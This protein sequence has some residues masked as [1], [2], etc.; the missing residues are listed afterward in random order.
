MLTRTDTLNRKFSWTG[1]RPAGLGIDMG[2][3]Q[4][5]VVWLEQFGEGDLRAVYSSIPTF[6]AEPD[7]SAPPS[8]ELAA[9]TALAIEPENSESADRRE[10]GNNPFVNIRERKERDANNWNAVHLKQ[11]SERISQ[12]IGGSRA[13]KTELSVT[14]SMALC[15]FRSVYVSKEARTDQ[16][17]LQTALAHSLG[18]KEQRCVAI[19][20][21]EDGSQKHRAFS[22]SESLTGNIGKSLDALG[23]PPRRVDG[24]PWCMAR[25][26]RDL[27]GQP[28][29]NEI[30]LVVDWG[31]GRPTLVEFGRDGIHYIRR[32]EHGGIQNLITQARTDF[33]MS[34]AEA[35]RWLEI[36][37]NE[38]AELTNDAVED[39]KH[40]A[41]LCCTKMAAEI[42]AAIEFVRWRNQGKDIAKLLFVGGAA[43]YP[44][45]VDQV[46]SE[47]CI[48]STA[49]QMDTADGVLTPHYATATALA[50]MGVNRAR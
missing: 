36:C 7:Y 48:E 30:A 31:Y 1:A 5:K 33:Q 19:L 34:S 14:L 16:A 11:L 4:T 3:F 10:S 13:R 8:N 25:T 23:L 38:G 15:D 39:T 27:L 44:A 37:V 47:V 40:W 41:R 46:A 42:N 6:L 21:G 24:L 49:W 45:L 32:L 43:T 28:Q 29:E 35:G 18:S 17:A 2:T 22:V 26:Y 50:A 12:V 9:M 20:P